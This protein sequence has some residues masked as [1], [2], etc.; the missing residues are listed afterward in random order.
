[1]LILDISSFPLFFFYSSSTFQR[2]KNIYD[3]LAKSFAFTSVVEFISDEVILKHTSDLGPILFNFG[4]FGR[5]W[6]EILNE[7]NFVLQQIF[8][9]PTIV[10]FKLK[11]LS[12]NK[13]LYFNI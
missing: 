4:S 3:F 12:K 11:I 8:N 7:L 2:F 13:H 1:M 9:L 10:I 5:L 6:S